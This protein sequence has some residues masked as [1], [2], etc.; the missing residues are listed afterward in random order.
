MH[1]FSMK[2]KPTRNQGDFGKPVAGF[3]ALHGPSSRDGGDLVLNW[4]RSV[5]DV[6]ALAVGTG[7]A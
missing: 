1:S 5:I 2:S 3:L 7:R 4:E 6:N